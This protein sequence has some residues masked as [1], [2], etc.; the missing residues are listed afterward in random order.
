MTT[1][2]ETLLAETLRDVLA[3][4]KADLKGIED[5]APTAEMLRARILHVREAL[6]AVK[7]K[8]ATR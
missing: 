8:E 2:N 6:K 1:M 7:T 3:W 5:I 4:T